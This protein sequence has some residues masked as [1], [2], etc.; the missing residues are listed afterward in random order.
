M[1]LRVSSGFALYVETLSVAEILKAGLGRSFL[2][3][4]L[5]MKLFKSAHYESRTFP[6]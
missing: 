6:H 3:G 2:D 4:E 1:E 5:T